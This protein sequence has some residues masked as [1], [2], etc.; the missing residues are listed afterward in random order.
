[1]DFFNS[2]VTID[3]DILA[4]NFRTICKKADT[5]VMAVI[6]ADGYGHGAVALARELTDTAAFFGVANISEALELRYAGIEKPI[7][8]LSR[9]PQ[10]TYAQAVKYDI[11]PALFLYDDAAALSAEA[12]RQGKTAAF[13]IAVD[14]GMN[15]IGF[16]VTQTDADICAAMAKLPGLFAEGIFSHFATAD[17]RDLTRTHAQMAKFDTFVAMLKDRG[18]E[19]PICHLNNSAGIMDFSAKYQM[20]RSGIILYGLYPSDEVDATVLPIRPILSWVSR[21]AHLK[22]IPA[23]QEIGYG[24][25]YTT[26]RVSRI[27]TIP[28]GYADGYRRNLSGKFHVLI[29]GR[30]A[31]ILGRVCMDQ[32]MVDVTDIPDVSLD[33]T[34][35][36]IGTD[37]DQQITTDQMA[38]V[39]DTINYEIVCGISRRVPRV[40]V[41]NGSVVHT[42]HYLP[43]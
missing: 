12:Q 7:L 23:G 28:V 22:T 13:H 38:Q 3:L 2:H 27:A 42:L 30:K 36:L 15:R 1:M 29:R 41:K 43:R 14:T 39:L 34:V 18:L 16:Q 25:T 32:F 19:I 26:T 4:D 33:D 31:P 9:M 35:T 40:Y 21:I 11:R 10:S 6:K 17:T 37:G 5:K 8:V 24:G 20:A